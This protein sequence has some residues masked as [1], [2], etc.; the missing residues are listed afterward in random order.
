MMKIPQDYHIHSRFSEDAHDPME[1][2]C[3]QAVSL[4]IP[5]IGFTEHWDAGPYEKNPFFFQPEPWIKELHRLQEFFKEQ[6]I[7][8]AGLEVAEPHLYP[9]QYISLMEKYPF[10]YII[11]SVHWVGP[12]FMFDESYIKQNT[13]DGI[14]E[15]YFHE[16]EK[17][18][19]TSKIDIVAHFDIP[20][21]TAKVLIGYDPQKYENRIRRIL[22]I[23][24]E[25]NMVLEIN[26]AGYRKQL[27]NIMPDP[28][29]L[30]WYYEMG[31]YQISL[32]SDAHKLNQVGAN[33]D[34]ALDM[35]T[36]IGFINITSFEKRLA[37]QTPLP[38]R[39]VLF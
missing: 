17:M 32:G 1:D 16:L 33:L 26:T 13:P 21:R 12:N 2:L 8:R 31:G 30:K 18:V 23:I 22:Q 19:S 24:I 28:I 34:K 25:R 36:S 15:P 6:L 3:N 20:V 14:Y 29:I 39:K 35:I 37:K 38:S 11:G 9:R 7:I 5:E 27:N 4:G 10:D